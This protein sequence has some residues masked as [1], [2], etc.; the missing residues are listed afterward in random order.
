MLKISIIVPTRDRSKE[1]EKLMINL[2]NQSYPN[3]EVIILDDSPKET[4]RRVVEIYKP[5]FTA[6]GIDLKYIVSRRHE[7]LTV[8]RNL[9]IKL[10]SGDIVLFLEDDVV[11]LNKDALQNL[12]KL[13]EEFPDAICIQPYIVTLG[14]DTS[15]YTLIDNLKNATAKALMLMYR[16]DN[17][18]AVRKS[19]MPILPRRIT[20]DKIKVRRHSGVTSCR[21]FIYSEVKYDENL[22]LWAYMEDLDFSYRVYKKYPGSLYITSRVMVLHKKSQEAR[23]PSKVAVYMMTIYWFYVFFKDVYD[24][25]LLNLMAFLYALVGN[26]IANLL[27]LLV[28]RRPKAEWLIILWLLSSYAIAFKNLR[29]II[30]RNLEFFNRELLSKTT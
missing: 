11:L 13:Y 7:G 10:A 17:A 1:L 3:F 21:K 14:L 2:L 25:S 27:K 23:L 22:K 18:S 19:C 15:K 24:S 6:R 12:A 20:L 16:K 26:I 28:E 5:L 29:C 9:G 30:S 4:A 8:A